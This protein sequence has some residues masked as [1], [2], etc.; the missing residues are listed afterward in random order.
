MNAEV[1]VVHRENEMYYHRPRD[2]MGYGFSRAFSG[3][4]CKSGC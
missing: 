1:H 3:V 4:D 2:F